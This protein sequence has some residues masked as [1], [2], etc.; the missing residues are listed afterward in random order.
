MEELYNLRDDIGETRNLIEEQPEIVA[1]LSGL[2]AECRRELGDTA[3]GDR[4]EGTRPIGRVENP[5]TL[6]VYDPAHPYM[7]AEYDGEAG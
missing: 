3:T 2:L 5:K 1:E 6:C 7:I 4:G